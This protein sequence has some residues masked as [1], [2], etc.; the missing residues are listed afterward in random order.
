MN[1]TTDSVQVNLVFDFILSQND[2]IM[3]HT[4]SNN[5]KRNFVLYDK[6]LIYP[7]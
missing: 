3:T 2:H 7:Y 4:K 5:N 1:L 6:N